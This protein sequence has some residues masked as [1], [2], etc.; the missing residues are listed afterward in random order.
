MNTITKTIKHNTV[1]NIVA[2]RKDSTLMSINL[3]QISMF[4]SQLW[5][6]CTICLHGLSAQTAAYRST[7]SNPGF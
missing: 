5:S 3:Q 4:I 6:L 1:T 2:L 7:G